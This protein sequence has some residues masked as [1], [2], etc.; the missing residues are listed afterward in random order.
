MKISDYIVRFLETHGVTDIFGYPGA[1][2]CH[3]MD[4]AQKMSEIKLHLNYHEQASAFAA[5]G[6]AQASG[7]LGVAYSNGG[8]GA[9]NLVTGIANAWYDS[10]PTLFITGQVDTT[11]MR[12]NLPIRQRGIQE[13]PT[14][15]MVKSICKKSILVSDA[16]NLRHDLEYAYW[17][18]MYGRPGPVVLE[19]PADIQRADVNWEALPGFTPPNIESTAA[20]AA[21]QIQKAL[22]QAKRPCL[23]IGN[24]V[25]QSGQQRALENW[26][27]KAG[28]PVVFSLPA[29]DLLPFDH[30]LN[31]GFI[32]SNG[33]R[34][35]NFILG[36]ADLI[37]T[38]GSR[39]DLKQVGT[40]RNNFAL[41]ARLLRVDIDKGELSYRVRDDEQQISADLCALLPAL[42]E[43][44][45]ITVDKIWLQ[46]CKALKEQLYGYDFTDS[47][48]LLQQ[49]TNKM[50]SVCC[51][52]ADVGQ[53]EIYLAQSLQLKK[54]QRLLLSLGLASMG[55]ALPASIGACLASGKPTVCVCGDGGFQMN[56]Q[57][58]H[59]LRRDCLPIT[60]IVYNNHALGMIREFQ[61][62]NFNANY[63]HS[64]AESGYTIPST[65]KIAAA[66]GLPY[67]AVASQ[68][69]LDKIELPVNS[70]C[71]LELL[72]E[73]PTY[74][75][76]R[77]ARDEAI[78]CMTPPL[79]ETFYAKLMAL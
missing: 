6:Y 17:T 20:Q 40:V 5:C 30:P 69:D 22:M 7:N 74:L 50:Q 25:R 77:M 58:L 3:L 44:G 11:A 66:Y 31:F 1:I 8:P 38:L 9:T 46:A 21:V 13:I 42:A 60:V 24:G 16:E 27:E 79:P 32:G 2:V 71:I 57:E 67:Y 62:R 72:I 68:E 19:I 61:E 45:N 65:K 54:G 76:P 47:H 26:I 12:G 34:Y 70:P 14:A 56:I 64:T 59:M 4:S 10:I 36:K 51:F 28:I 29:M 35:S 15:E 55:Y 48:H 39:L 43:C 41:N 78:Q 75:Y 23:L 53:H 52:L 73:E 37:V 49:L 33:H 63:T 18:A